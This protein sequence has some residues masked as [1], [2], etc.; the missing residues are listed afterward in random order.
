M[1]KILL[2][3]YFLKVLSFVLWMIGAYIFYSN[4]QGVLVWGIAFFFLSY[5]L[6]DFIKDGW[7]K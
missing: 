2:S 6:S 5:S 7:N 1:M 4:G 3:P